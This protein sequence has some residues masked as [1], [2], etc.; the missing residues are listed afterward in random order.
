MLKAD[1]KKIKAQVKFNVVRAGNVESKYPVFVQWKRGS[2]EENTAKT[3]SKPVVEKMALFDQRFAIVTT[4]LD[5]KGKIG[6]KEITFGLYKVCTF[7]FF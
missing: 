1:K 3:D 6:K 4:F 2:K 5:T 7:D